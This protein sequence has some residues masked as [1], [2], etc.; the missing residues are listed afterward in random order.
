MNVEQNIYCV[1]DEKSTEK[2]FLLFK[3]STANAPFNFH[4]TF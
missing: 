4:S 2:T 3:R 1:Q